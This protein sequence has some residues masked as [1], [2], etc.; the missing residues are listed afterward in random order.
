MNPAKQAMNDWTTKAIETCR[1]DPGFMKLGLC[2]VC[3]TSYTEYDT[4]C[5]CT[6]VGSFRAAGYQSESPA[7]RWWEFWK[8]RG[9]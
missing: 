7:R 4:G 9:R 6:R 1:N 8:F 2:P 3:V 5:L